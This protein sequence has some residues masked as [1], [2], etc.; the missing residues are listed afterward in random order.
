M[1]VD[2]ALVARLMPVVRSITDDGQGHWRW[3]LAGIDVA[4]RSLELAFTVAM[5]FDPQKR[6]DFTPAPPAGATERAS[7]TGFY[8][9][10]EPD[11]GKSGVKLSTSLEID[12]ELPIPRLARGTVEGAMQ[13]VIDGMGS[14][15]SKNLL[16]H[17]GAEQR[18]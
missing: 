16:T 10:E 6:I 13:R 8:L 15:F 18:A 14:S 1:L 9:L 7:V 12:V 2:P 5:T 17:L 4:G 3:R 11:D